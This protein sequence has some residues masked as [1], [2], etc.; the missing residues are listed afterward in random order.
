MLERGKQKMQIARPRLDA[1]LFADL[2]GKRALARGGKP[3]LPFAVAAVEQQHRSAALE[4][5]HVEQVI[6]LVAVSATSL[7]AAKAASTK[8]RGVRKS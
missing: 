1:G 2:G 7:P 6:A 4:A 3:R 8:T 5:E